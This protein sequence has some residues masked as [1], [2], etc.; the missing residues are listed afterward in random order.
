MSEPVKYSFA[1][2]GRVTRESEKG[3]VYQ[4]KLRSAEGHKLTL[5]ADS[6]AIFEGY[7]IGH[8]VEVI[9]AKPHTLVE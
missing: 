1:V 4:V 2:V 7:P 8:N 3:K 9:V 6:S 5:E